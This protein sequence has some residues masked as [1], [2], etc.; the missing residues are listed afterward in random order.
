MVEGKT[1][2]QHADGTGQQA[3][4][5]NRQCERKAKR[6]LK[7]RQNA[8]AIVDLAKQ[9]V[10]EVRAKRED[11]TVSEIDDAQNRKNYRVP[12]R[13]DRV[14]R[15]NRKPIEHVLNKAVQ[16]HVGPSKFERVS[17]FMCSLPVLA[18]AV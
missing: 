14:D 13:E 12:Q 7:A 15:T 6:Q 4:E 2:D 8:G 3:S 17:S 16:V 9:K 1:F 5:Q 10:R 18:R 11:R